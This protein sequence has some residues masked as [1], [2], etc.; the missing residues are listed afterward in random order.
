[1]APTIPRID[2]RMDDLER[3]VDRARQAPLTEDDYTTLKAAIDTLGYVAQ[4]V[5][6]KGTT[7]AGLRQLLFGA[8]TEKTRDVLARAGLDTQASAG[9]R[10][11]E[12]DPPR[13]DR[14][15]NGHGRHGAEAYAGAHHIDVPHAR[16]HHGDSCPT[17][18]KGK[19]YRQR[20]P[21]VL[22]RLVG[23]API[24]ATVYTLEKLRCHLCGELFTAD[25]PAGVGA[26]KYDATAGA[27]IALLN[28]GSGMPFYRL[29]RLQ[30]SVHI[31]LPAST[32]W[33]IVADTAARIRPALDEL[34]RGAGRDFAQ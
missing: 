21:G 3:L 1:M 17:C 23:Q 29:E 16:L 14:G 11:D 32:Q 2:L 34:I 24:A 25:P 20:E 27:M 18:A 19:V 9:A 33:E 4:L 30:A 15:A 26:D 7:L 28:Y 5:E 8:T 10:G 12:A 13:R 6:Q 31:P 22:I